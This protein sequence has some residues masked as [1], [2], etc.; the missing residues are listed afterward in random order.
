MTDSTVTSA[1]P[2]PDGYKAR[3]AHHGRLDDALAL[4]LLVLVLRIVT[5]G[6]YHFWGRTR[7]RRYLWSHTAWDEERLVYTGTGLELLLGYARAFFLVVLPV[8]LVFFALGW[9]DKR[10]PW[11]GAL[12]GIVGAPFFLY[13]TGVA[14][15][16]SWRYRLSR[17]VW[18]GIRFGL[19]G[20]PWRYGAYFLAQVLLSVVTGG[21]YVP[22]MQCRTV[23]RA[24]SA[25]RF[26][27]EAFTYDGQGRDLVPA[28]LRTVALTAAVV[29]T[30]VLGLAALAPW[31][32]WFGNL[33]G[34]VILHRW[35]WL[36][37]A[38]FVGLAAGA[39]VL[40][41][42]WIAYRGIRL[43]YHVAH[44]RLGPLRFRLEFRWPEYVSLMFGNLSLVSLTLGVALPVASVRT[45]RFLAARLTCAG[46]LDTAA[47]AQSQQALGSTGEGLFQA[48]DLGE[49]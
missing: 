45:A 2:P 32:A 25:A 44:T 28:Y 29:L 40:A 39:T 16:A 14:Q 35:P 21:M 24:V 1:A 5:L 38:P 9:V 15:Y 30:G 46:T 7:I 18:R 49:F 43:R 27:T 11:L 19:V 34:I 37:V 13:L 12:G 42:T 41:A 22:Y 26:G 36:L 31:L 33:P 23:G 47:I 3:A 8:Y 20:S 6:L 10:H 17:T 48:L 4:A